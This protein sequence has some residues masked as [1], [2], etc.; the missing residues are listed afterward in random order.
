MSLTH[1]LERLSQLRQQ[2]ALS[3]AEFNDAKAALLRSPPAVVAPVQPVNVSTPLGTEKKGGFLDPR[4]NLRAFW[5]LSILL[6]ICGLALYLLVRNT[7]GEK[8]ADTL[9][10]T[11]VRAPVE[12]RDEIVNVSANSWQGVP[13][14]LPYDG[15]L[16]LE[17]AVVDGNEVDVYVM[18]QSQVALLKEKEKFS[19]FPDFGAKKTRSLRRS[20]RLGEGT[21]YIVL[22]DDTLGIL[23]ASTSDVKIKATLEP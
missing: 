9:V 16:Q 11:A 3:E 17:I 15:T 20:G 5:R 10:R 6:G 2:G 13:I 21:Y 1:E 4:S 23:S 14:H 22:F 8:A 12:L 7:V 18:E 19:H